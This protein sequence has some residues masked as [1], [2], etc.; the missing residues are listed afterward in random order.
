MSVVTIRNLDPTAKRRIQSRAAAHGRSM[1]AE[2]RAIL[3]AAGE[4][5][6]QSGVRDA[7]RRS[8]AILAGETFA[9]PAR[10]GDRQREV[11]LP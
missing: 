11:P 10:K 2:M 5:R 9:P 1:E 7:M 8:R 4:P 3:E 6:P